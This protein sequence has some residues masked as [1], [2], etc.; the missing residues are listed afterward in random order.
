M[1]QLHPEFLTRDGKRE[2]AVLPYEEF[3]ALQEILADTADLLDLR[4]AK[5]Q[6]S[7]AAGVPLRGVKDLLRMRNGT[8]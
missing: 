2:F 1:I 7:S 4:E 8:T 6:E 3:V 5:S